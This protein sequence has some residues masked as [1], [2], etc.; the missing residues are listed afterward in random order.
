MASTLKDVETIMALHKRILLYGLEDVPIDRAL[1][2]AAKE[3]ANRLEEDD[4]FEFKFNYDDDISFLQSVV[5]FTRSFF[6]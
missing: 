6:K 2:E 3:S 4:L 1:I 5:D